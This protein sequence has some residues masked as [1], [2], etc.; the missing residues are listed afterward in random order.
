M[1]GSAWFLEGDSSLWITGDAAGTRE[2]SG[3]GMID[4]VTA[5]S[6]RTVYALASDGLI[7]RGSDAIG[8]MGQVVYANGAPVTGVTQLATADMGGSVWFLEGNGS[9][10]VT[11]DAWGTRGPVIG[12]ATELMT[13]ESGR[14]VYILE[15][16]GNLY[17][18]SDAIGGVALV[19]TYSN[20]LSF[21]VTPDG[22]VYTF[23]RNSGLYWNDV[24]VGVAAGANGQ[25]KA[26]LT[27]AP[28]VIGT[29][30]SP[31]PASVQQAVDKI[32]ARL[33]EIAFELIQAAEDLSA[34][35]VPFLDAKTL[36]FDSTELG[37]P[38]LVYSNQDGDLI[39][40]PDGT[41]YFVEDFS[42]GGLSVTGSEPANSDG[43]PTNPGGNFAPDDLGG[44][45]EWSGSGGCL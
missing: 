12:G 41:Y 7:Y 4:I 26:Y 22:S 1:G 16:D 36:M 15:G 45:P 18:G 13:A 30:S 44:T 10:W 24:L 34:G 14:T 2:I 28:G 39:Q 32:M 20:V 25:V 17:R 9:L 37:D 21:L 40:L 8:G 29:T 27:L 5:E 43:V 23:N 35:K 31:D 3:G 38:N 19:T 33:A 42:D 11:G 6:G